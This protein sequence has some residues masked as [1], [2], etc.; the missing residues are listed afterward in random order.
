MHPTDH[1]PIRGLLFD[2]DGTLLDFERTW[3]PAT[4]AVIAA[5]AA[6]RPGLAGEMATA[7]G[8][9]ADRMG[10][11]PGSPIIAGDAT[12]FVPDWARLLDMSCDDAF[13]DR[14]DALYRAE[15]AKSL[16]GYDD[17]A[18]ELA[19]LAQEHG[20][21][22]G[23][24]T[25]DSEAGARAHLE[26]LGIAGHFDFVAGY[27]SGYGAKP[28]P[29][30]VLAF[31]AA[32]GLEPAEVALVGDSAHDMDAAR[33]AGAQGIGIARTPAAA[34]ALAGHSDRIVRDLAELRR[35]LP[36]PGGP[37]TT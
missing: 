14:V 21:R 13:I 1:P 3:G 37:A 34:A 32:V 12:A 27:D 36:P 26:A 19:L 17:V 24:A 6:G 2:K 4:A 29:G 8:F 35:L 16:T 22:I 23:L 5:L 9:D 20:V 7:C 25:N 33:A 15:S 11:H 18:T 10:F 28:L 31:A 30:M